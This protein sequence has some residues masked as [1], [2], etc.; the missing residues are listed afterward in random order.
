MSGVI[1]EKKISSSFWV[2]KYETLFEIYDAIFFYS[3]S[4]I[5]IFFI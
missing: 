5:F 1:V 2:F 3:F 4:S